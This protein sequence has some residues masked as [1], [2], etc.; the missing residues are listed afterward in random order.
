VWLVANAFHGNPELKDSFC[1]T[2]A[3]I[4]AWARIER[5]EKAEE[6][7]WK[8]ND[9]RRVCKNLVPDVATF[10]SVINAYV[11]HRDRS[12][13]LQRILEI[14]TYMDSNREDQPKIAP[15]CFTH[16]FLLRAWDQ[17]D[18]ADSAIQ[19]VQTIE[20]M[21]RMWAA[22]DK[23]LKPANAYYNMAI[24]KIAKSKNAVDARKAL[25][26]L[27]LLQSSEFCCPDIISYTSAIE[28]FSKSKDPAAAEASLE[29]FEEVRQVYANKEDAKMMP[30]VR[31]YTMVILSLTKNPIL[32]HVVKARDMLDELNDLY[33][34]TNDPNLRPNAYP[35]NY[36]LSCAAACVG[37]ADDKLKAFHI[38]T[39]TLN[40]LRKSDFASP[41]SYTY[42][43][44]FKACL[45]LL[46]E[47]DLKK[48]AIAYS[49]DQCKKEGLVSN[50]VVRRLKGAANVV[51]I[52]PTTM[53]QDLPPSWSRNIR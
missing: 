14:V 12:Y 48:K 22:G 21:H 47:C 18:R 15:N 17:S 42:S 8:A 53:K 36:V 37:D 50:E 25:D 51:D 27:R 45:S 19:A 52:E 16:H 6:V 7:L 28:C 29:L 33:T 20:T 24:N 40:A 31:T 34:A 39:A 26:I 9:L 35:Y 43:F 13:G 10:N 11:N 30:N 41:D 49:F 1:N 38:A 23:S 4:S 46:P 5:P 44:W 2:D 3:V 32:K